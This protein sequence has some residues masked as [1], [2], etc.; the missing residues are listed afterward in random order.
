MSLLILL[1]LLGIFSKDSLKSDKNDYYIT[2]H[3][4]QYGTEVVTHKVP[5]SQENGK[6]CGI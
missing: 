3:F 5:A 4:I 1:I 2:N 6:K